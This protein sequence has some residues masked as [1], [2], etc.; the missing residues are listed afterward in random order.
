MWP[1]LARLVEEA[2][3]FF[4]RQR[5]DLR[6]RVVLPKHVQTVFRVESTPMS[7][8]VGGWKRHTA[9]EANQAL[10]DQPY[11]EPRFLPL[12]IRSLDSDLQKNDPKLGFGPQN[13][14]K[15]L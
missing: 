3:R 11:P 6:A 5:N 14:C 13:P 2:L 7:Q 15:S 10:A 12:R 8:I 1:D 4:H 9:S